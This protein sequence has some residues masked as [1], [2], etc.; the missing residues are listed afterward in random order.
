MDGDLFSPQQCQ[1][2]LLIGNDVY[3]EFVN[4]TDSRILS[5]SLALLESS[6]CWIPRGKVKS[7]GSLINKMRVVLAKQLAWNKERTV[8]ENSCSLYLLRWLIHAETE[9]SRQTSSN[10]SRLKRKLD[11]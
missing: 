3:H 6:F 8:G 9:T 5:H 2:N 1:I 4:I 10:R 7:N 11:W